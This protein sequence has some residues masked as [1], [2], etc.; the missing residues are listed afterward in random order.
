MLSNFM[1]F[2]LA[3]VIQQQL[4]SLS[5][6]YNCNQVCGTLMLPRHSLVTNDVDVVNNV[7]N[8]G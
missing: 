8:I 4:T 5:I 2:N 1:C 7:I 3:L 6:R